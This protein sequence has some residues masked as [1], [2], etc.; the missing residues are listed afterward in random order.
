LRKT[1]RFIVKTLEQGLTMVEVLASVVI[2]TA[3]LIAGL[4]IYR[5][6]SQ[7]WVHTT[8]A[9]SLQGQGTDAI[10]F[11]TSQLHQAQFVIPSN[12]GNTLC[13]TEFDGPPVTLS[14]SNHELTY[15]KGTLHGLLANHVDQL[16]WKSNSQNTYF[17]INL[18]LTDDGITRSFST[19]VMLQSFS[20]Q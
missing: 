10:N 20:S 3:V 6:V 8:I 1:K 13:V 2:S 12:Q 19:V 4:S 17:T 18:E 15:Q 7:T 9:S 14:F 16:T 11:L 5:A